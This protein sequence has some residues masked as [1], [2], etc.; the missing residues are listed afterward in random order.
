MRAVVLR[1]I[2]FPSTV[3]MRGRL[4]YVVPLDD[5]ENTQILSIIV[6]TDDTR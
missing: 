6:T 5:E 3:G 2:S 1:D 4:Q